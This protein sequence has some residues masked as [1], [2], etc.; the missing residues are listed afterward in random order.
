M[1][2][3]VEGERGQLEARRAPGRKGDA[4]EAGEKAD[5]LPPD[6][7]VVGLLAT[8]R[9]RERC[10]VH[11]FSQV[12]SPS[13]GSTAEKPPSHYCGAGAERSRRDA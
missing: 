5:E 8:E 13:L 3:R 6:G 4:E 9:E 2:C 1:S 12:L 11:R 10:P 7:R